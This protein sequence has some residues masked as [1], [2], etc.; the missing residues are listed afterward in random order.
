MI[1]LIFCAGGNPRL[2]DIAMEEGWL[3]G[4]RSDAWARVPLQFVDIDY[5]KPNWQK[6]LERVK[7]ECPKYA[8]T[9]DL[10]EKEVSEADI[11]R[12]IEQAEQLAPY[13]E[14]PLIIPKL[15]GQIE[16]IPDSIAV[17]YSI[18]SSYGG[19][20]YPIWELAGRRIHLLGGS[21]KK[22]Y[23]AASYLAGIA[24]VISADGNY[25]TKMA[26]RYM[27]FWSGRKW[28]HWP[29]F[30]EDEYYHCCRAS[31]RNIRQMWR[32]AVAA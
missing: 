26:Q 31:L 10:S 29:G 2:M 21:P 13:C 20:Q 30:G 1:D 19:A 15:P 16:Q 9:T 3:P 32:K 27:E 5:K 7:R 25:A 8:S 23:E 18:P 28:E 4:A 22:Q 17:G 6:H 24:T 11:A 14:I 12:A